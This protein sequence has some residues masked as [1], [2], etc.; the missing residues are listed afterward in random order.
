MTEF[1]KGRFHVPLMGN[2]QYRDNWDAIFG[3]KELP[4]DASC[5]EGATVDREAP[6]TPPPPR[7]AGHHKLPGGG[8]RKPRG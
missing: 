6:T 3:K 8:V 5:T 4:E 1:L 7:P 2:K